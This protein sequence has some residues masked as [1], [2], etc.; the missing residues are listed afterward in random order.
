VSDKY[1]SK[2]MKKSLIVLVFILACTACQNQTIEGKKEDSLFKTWRLTETLADIGDGKAT[3]QKVQVSQN[4]TLTFVADGTL[5]QVDGNNVQNGTYKIVQEQ[6][7]SYLMVK[8]DGNTSEFR[9]PIVEL[10]ESKLHLT[11]GCIEACG[12]KYAPVQLP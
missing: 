5:K 2:N 1:K 4:S 12:A 6:S 7:S 3:W 11:F 10:S 8:L 9:W